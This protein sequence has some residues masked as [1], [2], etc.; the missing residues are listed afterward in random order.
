M[1][2]I[3]YLLY[4]SLVTQIEAIPELLTFCTRDMTNLEGLKAHVDFWVRS[5][6]G[7]RKSHPF[8]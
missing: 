7:F 1:F 5:E 4:F 6:I 2:E 8:A 3:G